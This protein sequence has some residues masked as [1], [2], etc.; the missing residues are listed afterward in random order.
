MAPYKE[1]IQNLEAI[2]YS[3]GEVTGLCTNFQKSC[4][5]PIRCGALN[6]DDILQG[7]PAA[8]ASFPLRYLGLP[9]VAEPGFSYWVFGF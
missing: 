6:L 1:D 3:F 9:P 2:L 5:V 7:V 8:R 4:M